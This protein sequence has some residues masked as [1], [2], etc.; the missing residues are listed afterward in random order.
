MKIQTTIFQERKNRIPRIYG[1]SINVTI[2][3]VFFIYVEEK[4]TK[5]KENNAS[6]YDIVFLS[7]HFLLPR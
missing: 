3:M 7:K 5:H 2:V 6:I 1:T 4:K